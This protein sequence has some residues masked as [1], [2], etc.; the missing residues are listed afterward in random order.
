MRYIIIG[1]NIIVYILQYKGIIY[2]ERYADSYYEV[3]V[4]KDYKRLIT[5]GFVHTSLIHLVI[6]MFALYNVSSTIENYFGIVR[7]LILYFVSMIVGHLLALLI[8][9]NNHE[10]NLMS[11]GASGGIC[12]LIG[13]LL[14]ILIMNFGF[15]DGLRMM[16]V[17]LI[18]LFVMSFMPNVD[19]KSHIC[20]FGVGMGLAYIM[21]LL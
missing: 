8:N 13:A 4:R 10:D 16:L 1:I 12:G 7:Y 20:C 15:M 3:F 6:N 18:L 9:H 14:V 5:S 21:M 17:N 2:L 11:A 19:G